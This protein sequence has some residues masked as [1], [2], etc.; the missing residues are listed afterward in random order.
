MF[1][2]WGSHTSNRAFKKPIHR[3][4]N[5]PSM[6]A[7]ISIPERYCQ[8]AS[9]R[10]SPTSLGSPHELHLASSTIALLDGFLKEK[11][12]EQR[13]IRELEEKVLQGSF[14]DAILVPEA[15]GKRCI[16]VVEFRTAFAEDWQLSQ[17]W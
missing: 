11:A 1:R 7:P 13:L 3:G 15:S 9:G 16:S 10:S 17:F 14:D 8:T 2:I 4:H 12:E 5:Y 6:L